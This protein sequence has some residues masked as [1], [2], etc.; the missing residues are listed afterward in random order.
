MAGRVLI[1]TSSWADPG[2]VERWYP[3]GM[4]ARERLPWYAQRFEYVEVNSSFYALPDPATVRRWAAA[5]PAG[6]TFDYKL[7]RLLSRH[8]AA[9]DSLPRDMR[10][11]V[12]VDRR[13]RVRLTRELEDELVDRT[14]DA[15]EP[16]V[17]AGK[18]G[19]FLLQLTPAFSP[20]DHELEELAPLV[21]RLRP[22]RVAVELRHRSWVDPRRAERTF[23]FLSEIGAAFVT[24]DAPP[25]EHAPIMPPVDAVTCDEL[26]YMRLHGRNARGYLTGRT[27]AERFGWVYA[28]EELE[29]VAGRVRA[30]AEQADEVHVA[31][32]NNRD[33]DA[34]SAAR[35]FREIMGQ[36]P[37]PPPEEAQL[38]I[39]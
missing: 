29:E 26:A 8:A 37:G 10:D 2:F 11:E 12:E 27:V 13:G 32:N 35:R 28:D 25:G 23:A 18:L 3:R 14:R 34:P 39:A 24:V 16:L 38:R 19:A 9:P 36:D 20:F 5:T 17:E 15:V 31:F 30:L 22:H 33:D 6:F 21:E 1:G 7:H 4:P